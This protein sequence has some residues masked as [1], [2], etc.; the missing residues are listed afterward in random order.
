MLLEM[1]P[2]LFTSAAVVHVRVQREADV[3][4]LGDLLLC[5]LDDPEEI[6]AQKGGIRH[7]LEE[8]WR[9]VYHA[10]APR[11]FHGERDACG[12]NRRDQQDSAGN[13]HEQFRQ[14]ILT[15]QIRQGILTNIELS[16]YLD[17]MS[18]AESAKALDAE[19][20]Q[21]IA[22]DPLTA[23]TMIADLRSEVAKRERE[24][25]FRALEE[26][27]WREVGKALGVSKQAA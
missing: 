7:L 5:S 13:G 14:D 22:D 26:H 6:A 16:R 2:G 24:A 1:T 4:S 11:G 21:L 20:R 23:L 18:T 12:V 19:L 8:T 17:D 27:T 9:K 25:V 3:S 15:K 10:N